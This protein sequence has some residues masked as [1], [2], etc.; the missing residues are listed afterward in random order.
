MK[1]IIAGLTATALAGTLAIGAVAPAAAQSVSFSI[2]QRDRVIDRYC[3]YN[4][5][6][7]DCLD[8]Y[9]GGWNNSD[10]N[11]FYRS[12]RAG[13]DSVAAGLFG[14]TFGAIVAGALVDQNNRN[15]RSI[16]SYDGDW[17]AHVDACYDEFRSYD[18]R[19]DTYLGYD[20]DRHRCR[21]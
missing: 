4:P 10:Y 1:K 13:L 9:D 2:G 21:L 11:S 20:G 18:E 12:N 6:N 19:T 7:R 15:Q 17:D 5:R 3:D 8:Y 14:F 16:V